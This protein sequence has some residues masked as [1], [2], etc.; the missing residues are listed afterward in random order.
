M[1][2][3]NARLG[4]SGDKVPLK[5][6]ALE[7]RLSH[8]AS[9]PGIVSDAVSAWRYLIQDCGYSPSDIVVSGDS[10]GGH[11]TLALTRY[12]VTEKPFG[13][14]IPKGLV[15]YSVSVASNALW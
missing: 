5:G 14:G 2:A 13:G 7:Y 12:L 3:T 8:V 9:L 1:L 4:S 10:A 6:L 11:L 15:L